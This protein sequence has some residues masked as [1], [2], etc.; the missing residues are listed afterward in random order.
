MDDVHSEVYKGYT[1]KIWSDSDSESPRDWDN[2]GTMLCFHGRYTLGDKDPVYQAREQSSWQELA[3]KLV[4]EQHAAVLLPLYLFDHGG[5]T[6]STG[7]FSCPWDSGQVG[8]IYVTREKLLKEFGGKRVSKDMIAK[9]EKML[10][11]EVETYD[12]YLRGNVYGYTTYAGEGDDLGDSSD[13]CG[14]FIGDYDNEEYGPLQEAKSAIDGEIER[15]FKK[16][17]VAEM[18]LQDVME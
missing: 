17:F 9:A 8:F 15:E 11:G 7:K 18:A 12:H 1:I 4:K 2:L 14:G 5:I 13:S 6:M 3:D 10:E 16:K